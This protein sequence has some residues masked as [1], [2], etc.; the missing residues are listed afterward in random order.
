MTGFSRAMIAREA[1]ANVLAHRALSSILALIAA[2]APLV[3]LTVEISEVSGSLQ[4]QSELAARGENV[5]SVTSIDR[6]PL[7]AARCDALGTVSG[8]A[9]AGGV[10][11]VEQLSTGVG[12]ARSV[13]L[14]SATPG[15]PSVYWP[16]ASPHAGTVAGA[17]VARD[18]GLVDGAFLPVRARDPIP[19]AAVAQ[20]SP[21][22]SDFDL[23]VARR[24]P[25]RGGTD[26]CLVESEPGARQR[27]EAVLLGWFP[28]S[29]TA[30]APY[31]LAPE[32][33]RTPQAEVSGRVSAWFPLAAAVLTG[34]GMLAWWVIRRSEFALYGVLGLDPRGLALMLV[35]EWGILCLLPGAV[36]LANSL[37]ASAALLVEPPVVHAAALGVARYLAAISVVPIIGAALLTRVTA[38]DAIK[39]R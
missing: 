25:P 30:V 19:I 14:V 16:D 4:R 18:L 11:S 3:A 10:T 15:L 17:A 21:R 35:V 24:V 7:S 13:A 38:F 1:Y 39:G 22:S 34:F 37:G 33:G 8:V 36:G 32:T 26:E 5:F 20:P 9:A 12:E 28:E 27:V 6:S 29:A 2:V 23:I 31:F